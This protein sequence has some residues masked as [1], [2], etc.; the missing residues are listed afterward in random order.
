MW[1]WNAGWMCYK[2]PWCA[3]LNVGNSVLRNPIPYKWSC[4]FQG[5]DWRSLNACNFSAC[6]IRTGATFFL[7]HSDLEQDCKQSWYKWPL[8]Y[9]FCWLS[10]PNVELQDRLLFWKQR[11]NCVR[12]CLFIANVLRQSNAIIL[13]SVTVFSFVISS[14]I[15]ESFSV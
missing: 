2:V 13:W 5:A 4:R 11:D 7:C 12:T 15:I 9:T 8:N 10:C 14:K 3:A 6:V 1:M